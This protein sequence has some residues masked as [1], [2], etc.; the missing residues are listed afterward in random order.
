MT[1]KIAIVTGASSGIGAA[2]V[3]ALV[4]NGYKVVGLARRIARLEALAQELK[5]ES[6][7]L[8]PLKTDITKEADIKYAFVWAETNV[9]PISLLV[10]NAGIAKPTNIINGTTSDFKIVFDTNVIGLTIA[11]REAINLMLNNKV[12]NGLI[13]NINSIAGH[14]VP[15]LPLKN[16][17]PAS[18]YAVTALT[19]TL[20]QELINLESSIRVTSISPGY[21]DTEIVKVNG[22]LEYEDIAA[23]E[24]IA[25]RLQAEDIANAILYVAS[26]P[27]H[28]QITELTIRPVGEAI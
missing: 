19:E 6:G 27:S 21:V 12:D 2:T 15:T 16:V 11:C 4:K 28:V 20:R 25:P 24:K 13:V 10:N 8:F 23:I 9:G 7:K 5:S 3:K 14:F 18:K 17:Y 1:K 26:T 22:F